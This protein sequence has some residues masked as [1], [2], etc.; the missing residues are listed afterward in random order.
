MRSLAREEAKSLVCLDKGFLGAPVRQILVHYLG[1]KR[2][3]PE[4]REFE[5]RLL[6]ADRNTV[7]WQRTDWPLGHYTASRGRC[8]GKGLV[9]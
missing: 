3:V 4:G 1:K 5:W 8:L 7:D 2:L 9:G 6:T